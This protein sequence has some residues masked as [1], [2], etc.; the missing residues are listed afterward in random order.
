VPECRFKGIISSFET[1]GGKL[2]RLEGSLTLNAGELSAAIL[3]GWF[4]SFGAALPSDTQLPEHYENV[5]IVADFRLAEGEVFVSSPAGAPGLAW[6]SVNSE[7]IVLQ[8]DGL[9]GAAAD[10]MARLRAVRPAKEAEEVGDSEEPEEEP[11]AD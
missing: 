8:Q 10:V 6:S 1:K 7:T 4:E 5:S 9:S 2:S 11:V 3:K